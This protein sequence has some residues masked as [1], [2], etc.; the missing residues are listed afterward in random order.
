MPN[1]IA[2]NGHNYGTPFSVV[3]KY[4]FGISLKIK[5]EVEERHVVASFQIIKL[6]VFGQ[7][8][9]KSHMK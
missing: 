7:I 8:V 9:S 3:I 6:T 5:C 2:A 1:I 4:L